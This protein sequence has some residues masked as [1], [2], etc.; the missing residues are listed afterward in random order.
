MTAGENRL[1]KIWSYENALVLIMSMANGVVTLDRLAVNFLSP[2]IVA[3]FHIDNT[4]VGLL[5]SG[6]S[7]AIAASGFALAQVADRTRQRKL[8]LMVMILLF[9]LGS[10]L[11]GLAGSFVLLLMARMFLGLTEGPIVPIA[12]SIVAIESTESRR[13]LNMGIMLN[14]GAALLGIG[15]GPILA[16]HIAEAF[17]W[18]TAFFMSCT[19]GLALVVCIALFVRP[20]REAP[21]PT[22]AAAVP[23]ATG[24]LLKALKSRNILLCIAISGLYSSWLIIQSVFLP[25]YLV[26]MDGLKPTDM[27]LVVSATGLS[28]AIA[29]MAVPALSD[30]IGRRPALALVTFL[31]MGAPLA[32]LFVHGPQPVLAF[33]LFLGYLGGG[34]GPLYV[35]IVPAESV[36]PRYVATA[37]AVALAAGELIGGVAAPTL[38]GRAADSFTLAAPFWISAACAGVCGLLSLLL[39]ETAP[40]RV[41]LAAA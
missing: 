4:Q 22:A 33:A 40:R 27:G 15:L 35:G 8:I 16:T 31:G 17:G 10:A 2:Y 7:I 20:I 41:Q 19:P 5:A 30:R 13:G 1:R 34:A 36:P 26:R 29:G 14:L 28:T 12:Q 9:S 18:R 21:H 39:I 37:V 6:L 38:A 25:L 24:G 11:S 23:V 32:T 3:E